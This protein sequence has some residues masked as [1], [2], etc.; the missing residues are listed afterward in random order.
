MIGA[1]SPDRL[2]KG[3]SALRELEGSTV[4]VVCNDEAQSTRIIDSLQEL[5]CGVVGPTSRASSALVLAAQ[6]P[7]TVAVVAGP[8]AGRR[9]PGELARELEATW[10]VPSCVV[11]DGD[12]ETHPAALDAL[13]RTVAA[14]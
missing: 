13:R 9:S 14:V 8:L 1:P 6:T 2:S 10:G 4:L 7:P 5:G 12:P 11:G 3:G